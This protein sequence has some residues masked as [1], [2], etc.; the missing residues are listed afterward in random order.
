MLS[1]VGSVF[2]VDVVVAAPAV[3]RL[4]LSLCD[5]FA[6]SVAVYHGSSLS[7]EVVEVVAAAVAVVGTVSAAVLFRAVASLGI[8]PSKVVGRGPG[9]RSR[10]SVPRF[11]ANLPAEDHGVRIA[12]AFPRN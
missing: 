5:H 4:L 10:S 8:V 7:S 9:T 11:A 6:D 1:S 12:F 2:E 3:V